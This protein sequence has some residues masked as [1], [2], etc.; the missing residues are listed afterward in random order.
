MTL[1]LTSSASGHTH[2]VFV[3]TSHDFLIEELA[4]CLKRS[5]PDV[6]AALAA[7]ETLELPVAKGVVESYR[8]CYWREAAWK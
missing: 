5:A 3:Q 6:W 4:R 2:P 8:K 1:H 7:G